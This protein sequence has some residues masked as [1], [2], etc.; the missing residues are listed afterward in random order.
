MMDTLITYWQLWSQYRKA[1]DQGVEPLVAGERHVQ[2]L[3]AWGFILPRG[4]HG[5]TRQ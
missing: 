2:Q 5:P 1:L 3:E 4:F